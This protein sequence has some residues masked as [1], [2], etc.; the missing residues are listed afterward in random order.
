MIPD[1]S[2][3]RSVFAAVISLILVIVGLMSASRMPTREYPDMQ[4]PI[5]VISTNYR[6]VASDIVERRV[7]QSYSASPSAVGPSSSCTIAIGAAS[8]G[9]GPVFRIRR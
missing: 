4:L 3:R 9:L 6:G 8:P 2:V 1:L 7:T 5:V